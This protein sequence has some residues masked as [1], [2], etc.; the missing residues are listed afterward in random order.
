MK[1]LAVETS[2]DIASVSLLEDDNLV[3]E[4]NETS[5]KNH[6]EA[7]MP[8]IDRLLKETNTSLEDISLFACDNG[9]GSFTGIRI[10]LS[11][12][13]AFCDVTNKPC[14]AVSS[15]EALAYSVCEEDAY[16]CSLIDAKHSNVYAGVFEYSD[17]G[18][19]KVF[20]FCFENI[21]DFLKKLSVLKKKIFFVGNCGILYKD[22][23][24][25]Y[26]KNEV[27]FLE[28]SLVSSKYV[29]LAGF[30]KYNHQIFSD[31]SGL[32]ALYLK[33]SSAEEKFL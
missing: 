22:V 25:S 12:I 6:S 3:L 8:L 30:D 11:T 28:D 15:L 2:C 29:G 9:P 4:L 5:P 24:Q 31:S 14:T 19:S 27:V 13:K 7:L 20:D 33:K 32:S 17:D 1:I 21:D 16:V 18:Y 10:G 26:V 23:I